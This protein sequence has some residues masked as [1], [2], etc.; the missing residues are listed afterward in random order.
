MF[1][2]NTWPIHCDFFSNFRAPAV[3]L[4][5][6]PNSNPSH[7]SGRRLQRNGVD[8]G[9]AIYMSDCPYVETHHSAKSC[10]LLGKV[11]ACLYF[12][13]RC[14]LFD[15]YL[16]SFEFLFLTFVLIKIEQDWKL[17]W[18]NEK[19]THRD[20]TSLLYHETCFVIFVY[21]KYVCLTF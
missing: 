14:S 7:Q 11:F 18:A 12:W 2:S 15:W 10:S 21:I 4:N 8:V 5:Q 13:A 3:S 20:P 9:C 17:S 1:Q 6:T 16:S 19:S